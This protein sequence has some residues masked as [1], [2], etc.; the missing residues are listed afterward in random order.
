MEQLY[1]TKYNTVLANCQL[2]SSTGCQI[3]TKPI[4]PSQKYHKIK[5]RVNRRST[6]MNLH[7]FMYKVYIN[8]S[9]HLLFANR[10]EISHLCHN[11]N[12]MNTSHFSLEPHSTNNNRKRCRIN[13]A[14]SGHQPYPNCMFSEFTM[15]FFHKFVH[16][17][18]FNWST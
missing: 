4:S 7:T 18:I 2:D 16:I 3:Y 14:C 1:L 17:L 5:I 10:F 9:P 11:S 12:C 6:S 15:L 13:Q 8:M